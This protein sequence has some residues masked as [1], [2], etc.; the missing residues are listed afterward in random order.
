MDG[1]I[2]P[3]RA[4]SS[5]EVGRKS[6]AGNVTLGMSVLFWLQRLILVVFLPWGRLSTAKSMFLVELCKENA[7]GVSQR[8]PVGPW[9]TS[10]TTDFIIF[11]GVQLIIDR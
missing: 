10:K 8:F 1:I 6:S 7:T 5:P 3:G 9:N 11:T 4:C 2:E